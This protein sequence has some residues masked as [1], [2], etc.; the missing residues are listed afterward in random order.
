MTKKCRQ[1]AVKQ[2]DDSSKLA[3]ITLSDLRRDADLWYR[4]LVLIHDLSKV[5]SDPSVEKR[6]SSTTHEL[7]IS[8]PYFTEPEGVKVRTT[9]VDN[10]TEEISEEGQ[11]P[12]GLKDTPSSSCPQV[13][14]EEAIHN[15]LT[16]FFEKRRASGDS[17][18]CGPHDMV[19]IY[20][21]AFGIEKEELKDERFLSRVRRSG[22]RDSK[23]QVDSAVSNAKTVPSKGQKKGGKSK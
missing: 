8:P 11:S 6:L 10:T 22:L 4:I 16:N 21:S 19:P 2:S 23:T 1:S 9:L 15:R 5:G 18:P 14:L 7:Y 13:T 20:L 12:T 3:Q 17:R